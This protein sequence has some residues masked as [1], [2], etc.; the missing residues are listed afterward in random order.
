MQRH[1]RRRDARADADAQPDAPSA[2][3]ADERADERA[4]DARTDDARA[5]GGGEKFWRALPGE[6]EVRKAGAR[7][8]A[9]ACPR[10]KSISSRERG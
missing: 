1:A 9:R 5:D 3:A 10:F 4:A 7:A 8:P 2:D 6:E